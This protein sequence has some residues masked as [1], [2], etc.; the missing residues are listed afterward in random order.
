METLTKQLELTEDQAKAVRTV[1]EKQGK[2][3]R[4][5]FQSSSGDRAAMR[6]AMAELQEETNSKLAEILSDDQMAKF[7]E[8]QS[9]RRRRGPPLQVG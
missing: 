4:E 9:Q 5:L 6:S 7:T 2:Q 8:I 1:L 3:R